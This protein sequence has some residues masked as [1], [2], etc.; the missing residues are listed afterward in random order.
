MEKIIHQFVKR[1][2][3]SNPN[4]NPIVERGSTGT[5]SISSLVTPNGLANIQRELSALLKDNS[6]IRLVTLFDLEAFKY[7]LNDKIPHS[8]R[9]SV[10]YNLK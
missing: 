8:I 6:Q 5:L 1:Q 3:T 9:S 7:Y 10:H 2:A 4:F